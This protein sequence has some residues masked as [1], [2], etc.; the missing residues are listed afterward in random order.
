MRFPQSDSCAAT[1]LRSC[2]VYM[3]NF[4]RRLEEMYCLNLQDWISSQTY[5]SDDD[6]GTFLRKFGKQLP[7]PTVQQPRRP[8][9]QLIMSFSFV[10]FPVGSTPRIPHDYGPVKPS[11]LSRFLLL[12]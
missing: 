10:S 12:Q 2:A 6:V 11:F 8:D 1:S 3:G 7:N 4:Y 9:L 5:N